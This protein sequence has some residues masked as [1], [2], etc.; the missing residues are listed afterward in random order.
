MTPRAIAM[1]LSLVFAAA[2]LAVGAC[3]APSDARIGIIA[4]DR[5]QFDPVG[6]FMDHR[7]GSLDCH[8][9]RQRNFQVFGCEGLRLENDAG[10]AVPG[11]KNSGGKDT[12]EAE[13]SATYRSLVSLEPSVMTEVVQGGGKH[14]ELLTFIRK[15]RGADLH[16]GGQVVVPGD[17]Q[18]TC[19]TTWL[20]GST[21]TGACA[22]AAQTDAGFP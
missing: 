2:T 11:C 7:C 14:P 15:A 5:A 19:M 16:K 18:D 12:T 22:Q 3:S 4:P 1:M 13:F 21:D 10:T 9:M 6:K 17:A 8:G 20:A